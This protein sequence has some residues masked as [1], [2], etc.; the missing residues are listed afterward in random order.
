[1]KKATM[2]LVA[3]LMLGLQ[4]FAQ[5]TITGVVTSKEDSSPIPG[6]SV[7][8]KGTTQGVV[9]DFDGKYSISVPAGEVSLVF[10]FVGMQ[11]KEVVTANSSTIDVVMSSED[12]GLDEVVVTALGIQREKRSVTYQTERVSGE[13]LLAGQSTRAATGLV[14]KVAGLQINVQ[15]N[16]VNPSSQILLR[17]LRSISASNEALIVIDGSIATTGAF[18]QLNANDI[19]SISVLKGASAA[20]LYGSTASN[21]AILVQTKSGRTRLK[22]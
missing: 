6:V 3:M 13:E 22:L 2:M 16:G 15:D 20:A 18:N 14:G 5:R 9:T 8:V 19:E 7:V 1:M 12:V 21:G 17:G 4:V 11:T 10:S